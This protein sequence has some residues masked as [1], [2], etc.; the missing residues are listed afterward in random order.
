MLNGFLALLLPYS[1]P[2][3]ISRRAAGLRQ[4]NTID[5]CL[6]MSQGQSPGLFGDENVQKYLWENPLSL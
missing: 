1:S 2:N 4:W 5:D 6:Q 3:L